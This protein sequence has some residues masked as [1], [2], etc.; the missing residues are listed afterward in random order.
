MFSL[1][2]AEWL[3]NLSP[4]RNVRFNFPRRNAPARA[5]VLACVEGP[6]PELVGAMGSSFLGPGP[7]TPVE[8]PKKAHP[9]PGTYIASGRYREDSVYSSGCPMRLTTP[10]LVIE[11]SQVEGVVDDAETRR[12]LLCLIDGSDGVSV[13]RPDQLPQR[14][15]CACS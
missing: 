6:T 7:S 10:T 8:K 11:E 14:R 5:D 3:P 9:A 15:I 12:T 4:N 2:L 1:S 13:S